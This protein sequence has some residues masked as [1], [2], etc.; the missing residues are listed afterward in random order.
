MKIKIKNFK[1]SVGQSLKYK[2]QLPSSFII[3]KSGAN[4]KQDI[5]S[6]K[7]RTKSADLEKSSMMADQR[8]FENQEIL[9]ILE[10]SKMLEKKK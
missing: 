6:L 5:L 9:D 8:L 10:R 7:Q 3:R 2:N 1:K 4:E